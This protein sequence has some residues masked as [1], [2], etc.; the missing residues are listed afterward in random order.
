MNSIIPTETT[1]IIVRLAVGFTTITLYP[2]DALTIVNGEPVVK[3][4]QT[5]E[6]E[7]IEDLRH[8]MSGVAPDAKFIRE[9]IIVDRVYNV[10]HVYVNT[11][12]SLSIFKEVKIKDVTQLLAIAM[13]FLE[14]YGYL[15]SLADAVD[16]WVKYVNACDARSITFEYPIVARNSIK[17]EIKFNIAGLTQHMKLRGRDQKTDQDAM[18]NALVANGWHTTDNI[19]YTRG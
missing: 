19:T 18:G 3:H 2:G 17:P 15:V 8:A 4:T 11:C 6:E 9:K 12:A 7:F 10:T 16:S 5:P 13:K 14:T 1:E